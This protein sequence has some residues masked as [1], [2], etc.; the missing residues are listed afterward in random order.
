M[1]KLLT[2]LVAVVSATGL[3][4]EGYQ[5]NNLSTRQT[6]MGHVGTAM[7]LNSES[8][9]FNPAATAFQN[10][11]FDLSVGAAGILSYCTYTPSPTME[12]GLYAGNRPEWKSDNKMSTPI[13]AY[14][15]YKPAD[16]WAVGVGFFTPNGSSMNWGDNWP[17]ANLVQK[18]NLEAYTVQPTVSFKICDQVS[19]GAGLMVTWGN[20]D[21]SRSMLPVGENATTKMIAGG[22]QQA[23]SQYNAAAQQYEAA[24]NA[25]KAAEYRAM[26]QGAV[27]RSCARWCRAGSAAR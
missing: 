10:S 24:G 9:F 16:R 11:K 5:V 22:L 21:L 18:I 2:L 1:K 15:N 8:I 19:I 7:K 4:A 26:A 6:G 25:A 12:N 20:F 17:G 14:F 27:Q 13:Y 3:R 23:A